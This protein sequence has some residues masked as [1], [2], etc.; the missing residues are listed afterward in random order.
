[1]TKPQTEAV[2][3]TDHLWWQKGIIY[4]I[5]PRSFA[6]STGDGIGDLKGI[7]SR[8]DYIKWLGADAV[9][10][11]P[12]YPSP[13]A[14]FGYDISDYCNIHPMFGNL[15]DFTH[16]IE[17][18]HGLDLKV[19]LDFVPNHTSD[20]H[21]WF[22]ESRSSR[23]NPKRDWYIWADPKPDGSPP[24]NWLSTF[25]GPGWEF[26]EKTGQYYYHAFLRKQPDL[27]WRNPEVKEAMGNVL[28]FWLDRQVDGFRVDVI[29]HMIKDIKLRDNPPNPSHDFKTGREYDSLE[30]LYTT[31]RPEVHDLVVWMRSV[32]ESY[33]K[34]KLLIGEVYLPTDRLM[35]YYGPDADGAHMPYNF[36]LAFLPWN[37]NE[38]MSAIDR[39][40]SLLPKGAW[41]NWVLGNHDKGRI[42]SRVQPHQLRGAQ[43]LLLTLRGTPTMYYGDELGMMDVPIAPDQVK[44]PFEIQE[45]G[46]GNGRDPERT[47]MVWDDSPMAGFTT[48]DSTW[49]PIG[50][51]GLF[52]VE[53][54]KKDP[55]S[56][57]NMVRRLISL[58]REHK[59]LSIG[60][61]HPLPSKA[62]IAAYSRIYKQEILHIILNFDNSTVTYPLPSGSHALLFSTVPGRAAES[63][64][65]EVILGPGEGIILKV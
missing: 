35:A 34:D 64:E 13:M 65:T 57:L 53:A 61:F 56:M 47:P 50:K 59:A 24:N 19:I 18:A 41:P 9:W 8:L 20:E 2:P 12:I 43:M 52:N 40:E 49:L 63:L 15:A 60:D 48:G 16:L 4:Q 1:M 51:N 45:P 27:N 28:K 42:A 5:Y 10:L 39:Y 37:V 31:D 55:Q 30:Q 21:P 54:Q 38:I 3:V 22:I 33:G 23:D 46:K 44:D 32:L 26:D 58:R 14:D 6:D 11:S 29:W 25:G 17:K 7:I 62:P 36:Q